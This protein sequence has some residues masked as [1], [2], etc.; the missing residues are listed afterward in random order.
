MSQTGQFDLG[1]RHQKQAEQ[2]D[3][4]AT[5]VSMIAQWKGIALGRADVFAN[6]PAILGSQGYCFGEM[7]TLAEANHVA[8]RL[9]NNAVAFD[10]LNPAD[11][12]AESGAQLIMG[13]LNTR[14]P[15]M[16]T[17]ANHCWVVSGYTAQK[18]LLIHDVGKES[19]PEPVGRRV[20]ADNLVD[21][22]VL[23]A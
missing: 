14:R 3:C 12:R 23:K 7:A 18:L 9:T 19:G 10:A 1:I 16:V 2:N 17:M 21:A 20:F 13:L 4:W 22:V 15:L 8:K 11:L 5:C 6:A